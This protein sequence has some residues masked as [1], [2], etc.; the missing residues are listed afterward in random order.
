MKINALLRSLSASFSSLLATTTIT[1]GASEQYSV[2]DLGTL[3][4]LSGRTE[5]RVNAINKDGLIAGANVL[6]GNYGALL[7]DASWI[8]LG[9]LGGHESLAAGI[10]DSKCVVGYSTTDSGSTHAFLW[11][12][13]G[14]DGVE[15]NPQM[16]DLGTLGGPNSQAFAINRFG[17]V[18]GY[19]DTSSQSRAQQHAFVY[20]GGN[21]TDIGQLLDGLP[22]SFGYG[23][24]ASG[25]VAGTAYDA[26]YSQPHGFFFNGSTAVDIGSLNGLGV[27]ALALND[28]D[29]IVGY[30]TT[31][32]SKSHAFLYTDGSMRD[33]GT[34]G[35][36]Y[37]YA[38]GL[39]NSNLIV[40]GSYVDPNN[41]Q[42]RAFLWATN[43]MVDLNTMIDS[44]GAGWTLLE[45]RAIND[46]GQIV[47]TGMYNGSLHA[48]L[49]NPIASAA[50]KITTVTLNGA[51]VLVS[52][53]TRSNTD[54]VLETTTSLE[55]GSWSNALTGIQGTGGTVTVTNS[56][57]ATLPRQ[58]FRVKTTS[59]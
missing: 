40:G 5:A 35:G 39:N 3:T 31:V 17:Q 38:L 55:A 24:N 51:D 43:T 22:N 21:M 46:A 11:T 36:G 29:H 44:S 28:S 6:T 45:A 56:G 9:T 27:T 19:S 48:F 53:T 15:S 59:Q 20:S 30:F 12:P 23:I 16:K 41:S 37:S 8:N 25:H 10:N 14:T 57:N 4:D 47:G 26:G 32:D 18:T 33:L 42:Y 7:Y 54:Y 50:P 2:I 52:F 49:L 58:F 13:G 1:Y 34:L